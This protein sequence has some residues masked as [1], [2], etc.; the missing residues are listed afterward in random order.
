MV[1]DWPVNSP[2]LNLIENLWSIIKLQ[3]R[4]EDSTTKIKLIKAIIRIWYWDLEIRVKRQTLVNS[5]PNKVQH[6]IKND[7]GHIMVLC[8]NL[9]M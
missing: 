1:L 9:L 7:G 4:S 8:L 5:M 6:V 3:L 2:D